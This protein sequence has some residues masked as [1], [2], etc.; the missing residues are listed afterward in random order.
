VGLYDRDYMRKRQGRRDR[1]H[2]WLDESSQ[3]VS[4]RRRSSWGWGRT[5]LVTFALVFGV[6]VLP[7]FTIAG[8]HWRI[9]FF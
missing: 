8:H 6:L 3:P 2:S 9:W 5:M 7:Q 4:R 1:Y